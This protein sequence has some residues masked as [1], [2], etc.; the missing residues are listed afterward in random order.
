MSLNRQFLEWKLRFLDTFQTQ[1]NEL[2]QTLTPN[3]K[4]QEI[5][6]R[7]SQD[8]VTERI[9]TA[10]KLRDY[11]EYTQAIQVVFYGN[12]ETQDVTSLSE[13]I[14][15]HLYHL[16]IECLEIL[17]PV[18][19]CTFPQTKIEIKEV[20]VVDAIIILRGLTFP[21]DP[22]KFKDGFESLFLPVPFLVKHRTEVEINPVVA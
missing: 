16:E 9:K 15:A 13:L 17:D 8:N 21:Q 14:T 7:A 5:Y 10:A 11:A 1:L 4:Q 2:Y 20:G 18:F 22:Y 19:T 12:F 3:S 6:R